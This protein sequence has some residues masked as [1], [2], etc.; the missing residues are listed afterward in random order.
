ALRG[1]RAPNVRG[2]VTLG[3]AERFAEQIAQL[4]KATVV[5]ILGEDLD[6]LAADALAGVPHVIH[7]GT[8]LPEAARGAAV[9]LPATTVAE[10]EGTFVNRDGRVQRYLQARSGP[11]MAR[12]AWWALGEILAELGRGEPLGSSA[13]AF[14]L[15]AAE[16]EAFAGLSYDGL[17]LRGAMLHARAPA[18]ASA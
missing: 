13:E 16:V 15:L 17:G 11:G 6:G 7:V 8:T 2:A 4:G 10:E 5:V 18:G 14:A 12:P 3:Y 9:V 1:E